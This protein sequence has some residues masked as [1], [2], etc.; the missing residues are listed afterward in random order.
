MKRC[1]NNT[2]CGA[3]SLQG[4][5]SQSLEQPA[6]SL[7]AH[8]KGKPI[9]NKSVAAHYLSLLYTSDSENAISLFKASADD[10]THLTC[11][12]T[13]TKFQRFGFDFILSCLGMFQIILDS[14]CMQNLDSFLF[15]CSYVNFFFH[16]SVPSL[17]AALYLLVKLSFSEE[18]KWPNHVS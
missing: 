3:F 10:S 7:P 9:G 18:F 8:F 15:V 16:G 14:Y 17:P 11:N 12:F 2:S 4:T 13:L 6:V 1:P 5:Q